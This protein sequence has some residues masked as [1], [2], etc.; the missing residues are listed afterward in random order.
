MKKLLFSLSVYF[1]IT[2]VFA[3][4]SMTI[5]E[6]KSE[7]KNPAVHT[8]HQVYISGVGQGAFWTNVIL[9]SKKMPEL[10]CMPG[11]MVFTGN[12]MLD[13]VDRAARNNAYKDSTPIELVAVNELTNSFP[14]N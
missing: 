11:K 1:F 14:C 5:G 13:M 8:I 6:Y 10:F 3:G 4:D 2:P 7:M 9:K 12:I